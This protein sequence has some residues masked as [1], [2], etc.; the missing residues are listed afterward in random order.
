MRHTRAQHPN[1][2]AQAAGVR[3]FALESNRESGSNPIVANQRSGGVH[4]VQDDIQ[5][6]V[7]VKVGQRGSLG[8]AIEVKAPVTTHFFE[9]EV[10][11]VAISEVGKIQSRIDQH[12]ERHAFARPWPQRPNPLFGIHIL[13][14]KAVPGRDQHI[15][16]AIEIDIEEDGAP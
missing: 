4:V 3:S 16:I 10:P 8:N 5:I 7:A 1:A 11:L 14:V 2:C 15:L 13:R 12:L 6:A 9:G